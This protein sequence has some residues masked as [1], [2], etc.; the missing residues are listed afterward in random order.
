M[1]YF[2]Y[3]LYYISVVGSLSE[4]LHRVVYSDIMTY[5][6]CY[7]EHALNIASSSYLIM[8]SY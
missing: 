2:L 1:V 4:L 8:V 7:I 3:L 5:F 6:L